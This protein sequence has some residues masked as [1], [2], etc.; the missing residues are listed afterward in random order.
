MD[1]N[2]DDIKTVMQLVRGGSLAAAAK[3]MGVNYTTVARRVTRAEAALDTRLF[4]RLADGYAPT[5][6]GLTVARHG[7]EMEE[8][9]HALMR[10]LTA[11]DERLSGRLVISA[12]QLLIGPHLSKVIDTFCASHPDV[13][14]SIRATNDLVDLTRREADLAIRI[15]NDPGDTLKGVRLTSQHTASFASPDWAERLKR[16]PGTLVDWVVYDQLGAVPKAASRQ[17]PN[18]RV[19]LR[20]DDMVAL[21]GAAQAGVGVVR[22]PMFLGR[23]TP[24]LVQVP[25]LPPQPYMDIWVVAH[26]DVWPSARVQAFRE[27]LVAYFREYRGHFMA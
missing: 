21:V 14:L 11:K 12:P 18:Q 19:K 8:R 10:S 7:A 25:V 17:W 4:E 13:D 15:S 27:P 22:M 6:A 1:L 3:S 23:A 2:W 5:E 26:L 24:G 9:E 16:D 20:C